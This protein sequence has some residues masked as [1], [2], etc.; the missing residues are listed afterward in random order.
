MIPGTDF[1]GFGYFARERAHAVYDAIARRYAQLALK[2]AKGGAS[3]P[4]LRPAPWS[5]IGQRKRVAPSPRSFAGLAEP[6]AAAAR[7]HR[8][9][10]QEATTQ[11]RAR[12]AKVFKL[13]HERGA[14]DF[15]T[16]L[17]ADDGVK[18]CEIAAVLRS[19]PE[20]TARP[21]GGFAARIAARDALA[22]P[23]PTDPTP[24][25][26]A[27]LMAAYNKCFVGRAD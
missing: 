2:A 3:V 11:Q 7:P 16:R 15:A 10:V 20:E 27:E 8:D 18:T 9:V 6:A 5:R 14:V 25:A 24:N 23:P 13:A 19:M 4:A 22:A 17:L 26:T 1:R 21:R 12:L